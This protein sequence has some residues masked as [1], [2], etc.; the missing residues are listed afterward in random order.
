[1][2]GATQLIKLSRSFIASRM[3]RMVFYT[4]LRFRNVKLSVER[5]RRIEYFVFICDLCVFLLL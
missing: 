1:M 5:L 3:V 2:G 4:Y